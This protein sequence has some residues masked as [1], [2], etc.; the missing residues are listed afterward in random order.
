LARF[1]GAGDSQA[2]VHRATQTQEPVAF[3]FGAHRRIMP[4]FPLDGL[5]FSG[6]RML[7]VSG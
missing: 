1:R 2:F 7:L 5:R 4:L 3:L 6:R